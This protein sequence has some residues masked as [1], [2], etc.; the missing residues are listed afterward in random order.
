MFSDGIRRLVVEFGAQTWDHGI[1]GGIQCS[2]TKSWHLRVEFGAQGIQYFDL[3]TANF[4]IVC[5]NLTANSIPS[6]NTIFPLLSAFFFHQAP[7]LIA[8][9][10]ITF[11][12]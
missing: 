2:E 5:I 3:M 7:N 8:E 11:H 4:T 1:W 12:R 9:C 6:P 10:L